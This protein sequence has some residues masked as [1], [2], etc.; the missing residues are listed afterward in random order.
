[1]ALFSGNYNY[2]RDG[3]NQ[4]GLLASGSLPASLAVILATAGRSLTLAHAAATPEALALLDFA[5]SDGYDELSR[6]LE[7]AGPG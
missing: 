1:V 4:V 3:A 7:G 6:E 2:V 5:L